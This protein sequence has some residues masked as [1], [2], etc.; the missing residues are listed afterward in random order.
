M[1]RESAK[2]EARISRSEKRV[3]EGSVHQLEEN[4]YAHRAVL[5]GILCQ[6]VT[7]AV[8][9]EKLASLAY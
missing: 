7:F 6:L 4:K 5:I 2:V 1:E 3:L 8:P 9:S